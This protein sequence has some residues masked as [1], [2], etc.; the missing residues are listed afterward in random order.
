MTFNLAGCFIGKSKQT[1]DVA[2]RLRMEKGNTL[3]KMRLAGLIGGIV[4][5]SYANGQAPGLQVQIKSGTGLFVSVDGV[6]V[7]QGSG[8]QYYAPGWT[9]GYY[10]TQYAYQNVKEIASNQ[11]LL[12]FASPDGKASGAETFKLVGGVLTVSASLN[13]ASQEPCSI[14]CTAAQVWG[15]AVMSSPYQAKGSQNLTFGNAPSASESED[16]R[17]FS[18]LTR[19]VTLSGRWGQMKFQVMQPQNQ[20]IAF[21]ARNWP[22]DWTQGKN[23][24]WFGIGG[25]PIT[26]GK[27]VTIQ[28][29]IQLSPSPLGSGVKQHV[30]LTPSPVPSATYLPNFKLPLLPF[31]K[32]IHLSQDKGLEITG[33][34]RL[35]VGYFLHINEFFDLL[36]NRF[37]LEK[38]TSSTP[39]VEFDGGLGDLHLPPEAFTIKIT[40]HGVS[41]LGEDDNG[42]R[43]GLRRLALLAYSKGGK[44]YLPIG[45]MTDWPTVTWRGFHL[46]SGPDAL[47]FQTKLYDRVLGPLGFNHAVIQCDRTAWDCLPNVRG[48]GIMSK[49]DLAKLF[50]MYRSRGIS[51][52]P[53]IESFGH[54]SWL[55]KNGGNLNLAV[56]PN[57]PYALDPRKIGTAQLLGNIW[58]EAIDLL[59]PSTIHFGCD[60]VDMVGFPENQD[61][62]TQL[63]PLQMKT[64]SKIATESHVKMMLWGDE[65]LAKGQAPDACNAPS[66]AAAEKRLSAIPKGAYIADWHY[67]NNP[68][69]NA[70]TTSLNYWQNA[71]L[72]PIASTWY[73]SKNVAGFD[74][75]AAQVKAGTLQTTWCG[76]NSSFSDPIHAFDQFAAF[77]LAAEYSWTGRQD[78]PDQLSYNYRK[79]FW[80]LYF[81]GPLA[82][83]PS[84]GDLCSDGTTGR[85]AVGR[86]RF[87]QIAPAELGSGLDPVNSN[88]PTEVQFRLT[89]PVTANK[90]AVACY[91][92]HSLPQHGIAGKVTVHLTSGKT[93]SK[94][95]EYGRDVRTKDSKK[96]APLSENGSGIYAVVIPFS[97]AEDVAWIEVK[98]EGSAAGITVVGLSLLDK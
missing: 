64:L 83:K 11:Y 72:N 20:W 3:N 59:H 13:W 14:E 61:L 55:F 7:I 62:L 19:P 66:E 41:V 75:A 76:V 52:I 40:S 30:A 28:Y 4:L 39:K 88:Y 89:S 2:P 18:H 98:A 87:D 42:L 69:F 80:H 17:T 26:K 53:L 44:V 29:S 60:E 47:P 46:F 65:M 21:D 23:F 57:Q 24:L 43:F 34:W 97:K 90:L 22:Q 16:A 32:Q 51:P 63:W 33:A 49:Q 56:N 15:D 38:P 78:P 84:A 35:P 79:V 77:V 25:C 81:Q 50:A 9:K 8:I 36:K 71:G 67:A 95:L 45:T 48:A 86:Y 93:V 70:Y 6:P 92:A 10:S 54:D 73:Q 58:K 1:L 27:T 74:A 31:P 68:D 96:V 85:F 82:V 12:T 91:C 94:E 37:T 5:A